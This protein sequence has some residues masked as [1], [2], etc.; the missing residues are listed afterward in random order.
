M[1]VNLLLLETVLGHQAWQQASLA[2]EPCHQPF[3]IFNMSTVFRIQPS[4]LSLLSLSMEPGKSPGWP[5]VTDLSS[6]PGP[7]PRADSPQ[8]HF[9]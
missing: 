2:T 1:G 3:L 4:A 8:H 6:V 5:H 7:V 9:S